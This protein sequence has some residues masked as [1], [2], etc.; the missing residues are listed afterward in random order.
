M[1]RATDLFLTYGSTNALAGASLAADAGESIALI[2]PSGSGKTSFLQCISGLRQPDNGSVAFESE[3]LYGLSESARSALRL[4]SF[5]FVFQSSELISELSLLENIAL[6]LE[7]NGATR[8]ASIKEARRVATLLDLAESMNRRPSKVSGGQ[9][10]RA[11]IGRAIGIRPKVVFADEPTGALDGENR[12]LVMRLLRDL[13]VRVGS[14]LIVVT[15]DPDVARSLGRQIRLVD[16]R[17]V[18]DSQMGSFVDV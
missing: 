17:V 14:L 13:C 2:G 8:R 18:S 7:L 3:D 9:R 1:L 12:E 5:G 16:G 10:Q 6:P 4:K 15:H 11:A